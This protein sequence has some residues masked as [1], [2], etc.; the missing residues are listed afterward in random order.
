MVIKYNL[1]C[2]K[3]NWVDY[4]KSIILLFGAIGGVFA[5]IFADEWG[6]RTVLIYTLSFLQITFIIQMIWPNY[7]TNLLFI[8]MTLFF[9]DVFSELMAI[10]LTEQMN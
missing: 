9:G 7:F 1:I 6:R 5:G 4:S 8:S 2:S 3:W 10:I